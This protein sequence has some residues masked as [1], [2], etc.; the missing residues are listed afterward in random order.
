MNASL[1]EP[2]FL[3]CSI[4]LTQP[5]QASRHGPRRVPRLSYA[6]QLLKDKFAH[7]R[8]MPARKPQANYAADQAVAKFMQAPPAQGK[9]APLR[10]LQV[11]APGLN[12]LPPPNVLQ[13][14]RD[15]LLF[16]NAPHPHLN[17][18]GPAALQAQQGLT[19]QDSAI[20]KRDSFPSFDVNEI[21]E[22]PTW[23]TSFTSSHLSNLPLT[24]RD[25]A[26]L[27]WFQSLQEGIVKIAVQVHAM[28]P[29]DQ[30]KKIS[31]ADRFRLKLPPVPP[32][33]LVRPNKQAPLILPGMDYTQEEIEALGL[34]DYIKIK[35]KTASSEEEE[36][37][38]V[39]VHDHPSVFW[40]RLMK[41]AFRST[42][43]DVR[44]DVMDALWYLLD[45]ISRPAGEVKKPA[46]VKKAV[47]PPPKAMKKGMP[48][49]LRP[50]DV[51]APMKQPGNP[52]QPA[53]AGPGF[54]QKV[55]SPKK[56][57]NAEVVNGGAAKAPGLLRRP[58]HL[59]ADS[60]DMTIDKEAKGPGV[61]KP[62]AAMAAPGNSKPKPLQPLLK[63][64]ARAGPGKNGLQVQP[65]NGF[66]PPIVKGR[67][68][69][70][71]GSGSKDLTDALPVGGDAPAVVN[72]QLAG[73]P[74][75]KAKPLVPKKI[76]DTQ[77]DTP[78]V[79]ENPLGSLEADPYSRE[80]QRP[81]AKVQAEDDGDAYDQQYVLNVDGTISRLKESLLV[82]EAGDVVNENGISDE[83]KPPMPLEQSQDEEGTFEDENLMELLALKQ[84]EMV[85]I[86]KQIAQRKQRKQT[87]GKQ[88]L[89][90]ANEF[91]PRGPGQK[92][93][94]DLLKGPKVA[95]AKSP[96]KPLAVKN[97]FVPLQAAE[98]H[99]KSPDGAGNEFEQHIRIAQ[100]AK[101][102]KLE[103][104]VQPEKLLEDLEEE[105]LAHDGVFLNAARG[106]NRPMMAGMAKARPVA[107]E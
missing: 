53:K 49:L 58:G 76:V 26:I 11:D 96:L 5:I 99:R 24:D 88:K 47:P 74:A 67:L 57:S 89:R 50:L 93:N 18:L 2:D 102:I 37:E 83:V 65:G 97:Q 21:P 30:K 4:I 6:K 22:P 36:E 34:Q 86:Q 87:V 64:D 16:G 92:S 10:P 19:K 55:L 71:P 23:L 107:R 51:E 100:Q 3:S 31:N 90:P 15:Q 27:A 105:N 78:D 103:E 104:Q 25:D 1:E 43:K 48:G 28:S 95:K 94:E 60:P 29:Q 44:T 84:Q 106:N 80:R 61:K 20:V 101:V 72:G 41:T 14:Q 73:Q 85:E 77:A 35:T 52:L 32:K 54:G 59:A 98:A 7:A 38:T 82:D 75:R 81:I 45:E 56:L 79:S 39:T 17:P 13:A 8:P 68:G 63:P 46:A 91:V 9:M 33:A 40:G 42:T 69:S 12:Q 62:L 66:L 70:P